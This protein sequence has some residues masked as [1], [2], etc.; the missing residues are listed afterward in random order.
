MRKRKVK[1]PLKPF[2]VT[3]RDDAE[4]QYF[5][6]MKK[7]CRYKNMIVE[8]INA[9]DL[10]DLINKT[11][12]IKLQNKYKQAWAV[13]SLSQYSKK[14]S[15]ISEELKLAEVKK[16]NVAYADPSILL[17]FALHFEQVSANTNDGALKSII[18]KYIPTF[19]WS[20]DYLVSDQGSYFNLTLFKD[21]AKAGARENDLNR[22]VQITNPTLTQMNFMRF[23]NDVAE[24]CGEGDVA[25]N[26]RTIG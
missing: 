22:E 4:Y 8:K 26:Q 15:E 19:E 3:T 11:Q 1:T 13:C 24:F 20:A 16:V 14:A 5:M 17:Y 12:K 10:I 9:I 6:Q 25:Y 7:D 21:K 18:K 2:L 23:M